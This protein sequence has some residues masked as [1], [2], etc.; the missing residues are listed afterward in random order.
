MQ[1]KKNIYLELSNIRDKLSMG[2]G[3]D[4]KIRAYEGFE[5]SDYQIGYKQ[6][7]QIDSA[8][9]TS[10]KVEPREIT[11]EAECTDTSKD[12]VLRFFNP[13]MTGKLIVELNNNK[14]WI[15]YE[16]KSLKIKQESLYEPIHFIVTLFCA[17]PFFMDMSDFGKDIA[18]SVPLFAFPFVW[19]VKRDYVISYR[20]FSTNFMIVNGGDVFTGMKVDF[21]A[22]DVVR[23][24]KLFL[25]DGSF[26]RVL[27]EMREGD[28][29]TINTN[30]GSKSIYFNGQNITNKMDRMSNFIG[31]KVGENVLTYTADQGYLHLI[32]RLFYTPMY[33]GV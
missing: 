30:P 33:L 31:L 1:I 5:A 11:I 25:Q 21:I 10:K 14:R 12:K 13:K 32:V 7:A 17:Q 3:T 27:V 19:K 28:T 22:R 8:T 16:V 23:N 15:N 24:P 2:T 18:A 20:Q 29:L 6:N 26:I 4:F 9:I